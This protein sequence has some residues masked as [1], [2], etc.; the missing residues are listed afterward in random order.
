MNWKIRIS[1]KTFWLALIPA[2][3]LVITSVADVFG[4]SLDF[5]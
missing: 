4:Y 1:N 3:A 5:T 2:L